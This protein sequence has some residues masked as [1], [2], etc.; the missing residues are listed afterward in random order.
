[1]TWGDVIGFLIGA[2][3]VVL[4]LYAAWRFVDPLGRDD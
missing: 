3:F 1:M 4:G 2:P